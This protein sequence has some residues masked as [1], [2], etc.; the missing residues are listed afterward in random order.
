MQQRRQPV[1]IAATVLMLGVLIGSVWLLVQQR[2][3]AC[4]RVPLL[5]D[6]L[7]P[8]ASL[9]PDPRQPPMPQGWR[10]AAPGVQLGEFAIDG[11]GRALHLMGIANYAETPPIAVQ[12]GRSYCFVGRA[13][14]DSP[15]GSA[16][17]VQVQAHWQD[18]AG[19]P[20][21]S[22]ASD[23]QPVV[24]WQP[25]NPPDDWSTVRAAFRAP[26]GAATLR[27]RVLPAADD[28]IYLDALRVQRGGQAPAAVAVPTAAPVALAPWPDGKQA[29]VSFSF[30]WETAMGGLVHSRSV[31]DPNSALDP[32]L[33]GWRMREGITT[34]LAIFAPYGVRATYF[35]TGYNFLH[36]N[37]ERREF[38]GNP[39]Y[40]WANTANRWT[41]NR[42]QQQPWFAPDPYGTIATH[43]EWYFADL[44]P[45]LQA[46]EQDIQSHTFSH[47]Y[48]GFVTVA[49]WQ[50]DIAAWRAEAATQGVPA[51]SVL[52]FP[53]SSSGGMSDASWQ[54]LATQGI[55]TVTR[56]SG[57]AQ[58]RLFA[59]D[60]QGVVLDP[61]C[62]PLPAH[63]QILACPD[64]YLT[65]DSAAL[66]IAQ[67]DRAVAA[68]G[69]IDL[70]AHTE[71][72]I[73]AEQQAAW[74]RVVHYAAT[75]P[76]VWV[77]PLREIS[78]WQRAREQV[79][80]QL[81]HDRAAV[82]TVQLASDHAMDKLGIRLPFAAARVDVTTR[83]GAVLPATL[84][85]R[86]LLLDLPADTVEIRAWRKT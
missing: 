79:Q 69:M 11:D 76:Q 67:I 21:G 66:A 10:A 81:V 47:F 73:S 57:Q 72:V 38:L 71:E 83:S 49:E 14:T 13:I 68:G 61:H 39:T 19:Q 43:P 22:A 20:L 5:A 28:R 41:S 35:A 18:A 75:H 36:G 63:P 78:A 42:W 6:N 52:A 34:T 77:A 46:A 2:M 53:W 30:D 85:G 32:L 51:A 27:L 86:M 16:T 45:L 64:F 37:P 23:W 40:Q 3:A 44:I 65:P 1:L 56:T 80:V 12:A 60:S 58:F 24:L 70:W 84:E 54:M 29:A 15:L 74:Q 4:A 59:R 55:T 31:D 62:R 50:A 25:A 82:L 26:A 48:G 9:Q 33:R 8:N 17:R 7:L